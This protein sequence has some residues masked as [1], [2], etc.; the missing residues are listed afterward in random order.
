MFI[1]VSAEAA[2]IVI[3][4]EMHQRGKGRG[5]DQLAS[6]FKQARKFVEG[7]SGVGHMLQHFAAQDGIESAFGSGMAVMSH[8][9]SM[10]LVS[11]LPVCRPLP[12]PAP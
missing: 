2:A 12:S 6:G 1:P 8:T 4:R 9:K 11:H 5:Q 10:R 3:G 7:L